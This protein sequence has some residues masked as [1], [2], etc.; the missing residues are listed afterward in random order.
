MEA[1][2][3]AGTR[4]VRGLERVFDRF[5]LSSACRGVVRSRARP[6]AHAVPA[7]LPTE[8]GKPE[9]PAPGGDAVIQIMQHFTI[10][11]E[12]NAADFKRR[13]TAERPA[14]EAIVRK[15]LRD[16]QSNTRRTVHAQ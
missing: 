8:A 5:P 10:G 4:L 12:A 2:S 15:I 6:A 16:I 3:A 14:F 9:Q 11:G 7:G 13:L 1:F